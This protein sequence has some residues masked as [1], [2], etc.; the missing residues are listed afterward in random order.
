MHIVV[1]AFPLFLS[2]PM[3][4]DPSCISILIKMYSMCVYVLEIVNEDN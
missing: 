3:C 4:N 2:P 1:R